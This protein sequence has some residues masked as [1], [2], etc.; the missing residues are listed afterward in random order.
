MATA[1]SVSEV[2]TQ[3]GLDAMLALLNTGGAGVIKIF[4]GAIPNN[5]ETADT[6]TLLATLTLSATAFPA[7]ATS[8]SPRGAIATANA[9]TAAVAGNTGTA[10][11]F[12]AYRH[13][14]TTTNADVQGTCGT[15]TADL[16]LNTTSIVS[17]GNVSISSWTVTLPDGGV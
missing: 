2:A 3:A 5:T 8:S 4:S 6:G 7:S 11:Y 9:I 10:G 12:R 1:P 13:T 14:P 16:I 17:G 15:A